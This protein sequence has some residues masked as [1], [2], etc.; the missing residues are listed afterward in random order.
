V[1]LPENETTS[2]SPPSAPPLDDWLAECCHIEEFV[3]RLLGEMDDLR[4]EVQRKAHELELARTRLDERE[5]QLRAQGS[6]SKQVRQMLLRQDER[7]TA[8]LNELAKLRSDLVAAPAA[9]VSSQAQHGA[10]LRAEPGAETERASA[11]GAADTLHDPVVDSVRK[12]FES[13]RKDAR[14]RQKPQP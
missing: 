9:A 11:R 5:Q 13:L 6:E 12:Q 14:R 8:A 3:E 10:G 2:G 7:L 4:C 1:T